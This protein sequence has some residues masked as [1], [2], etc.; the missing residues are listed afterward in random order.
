[1]LSNGL[2]PEIKKDPCELLR[3]QKNVTEI[4][5]ARKAHF[6]DAISLVK[7]FFF[8]WKI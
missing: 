3:S 1:M 6:V 4:N 2:K 7:Y 8:G 5:N